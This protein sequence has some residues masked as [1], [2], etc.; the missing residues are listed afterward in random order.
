MFFYAIL[1]GVGSTLLVVM[2]FVLLCDNVANKLRPSK[3]LRELPLRVLKKL[4]FFVCPWTPTALYFV[5]FV[6]FQN[7][8]E[9]RSLNQRIWGGVVFVI[10]MMISS[11]IALS[12]H[13]YIVSKRS[14]KMIVPWDRS[15]K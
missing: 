3:L 5:A 14:D 4:I 6:L 1:I 2:F 9:D 8:I 7:F 12:I 10:S 15:R 13:Q 11:I